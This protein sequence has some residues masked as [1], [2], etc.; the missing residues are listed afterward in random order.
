MQKA[1]IIFAL[2][3]QILMILNETYP[4]FR[5]KIKTLNHLEPLVS[6]SDPYKYDIEEYDQILS[7]IE[8]VCCNLQ[9]N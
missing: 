3:V 6:L 9:L 8:K 4:K 1:D 7:N 5:H 2:D